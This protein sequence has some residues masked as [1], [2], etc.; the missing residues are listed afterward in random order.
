MLL[1]RSVGV[2]HDIFVHVYHIL[3]YTV[4]FFSTALSWPPASLLANIAAFTFMSY[5]HFIHK[6]THHM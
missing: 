1:I 4:P 5:I 6:Y 3:S 2:H